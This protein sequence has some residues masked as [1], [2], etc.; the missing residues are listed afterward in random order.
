M[1]NKKSEDDHAP[2]SVKTQGTTQNVVP[3][4]PQLGSSRTVNVT[5]PTLPQSQATACIQFEKAKFENRN[6]N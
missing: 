6:N 4:E 2:A 3:S 1:T 5:D